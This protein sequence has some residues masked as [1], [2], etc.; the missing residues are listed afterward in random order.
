[1]TRSNRPLSNTDP[2]R[3]NDDR[4]P[5]S[6][7]LSEGTARPQAG[8]RAGLKLAAFS[9]WL[10]TYLSMF[11][12]TVVLFFSLTGITLNHP[13]FFDDGIATSREA[14]GRVAAEWVDA[15]GTDSDPGA[16]I[17]KLEV[18]EH[19]RRTHGL[20]GAL[21]SFTTDEDECVVTFKGPGYSAD[22]FIRRADGRY[23]LTEERR[24]VVAVLND[25]HKGRDAGPVWSALVDVSAALTAT[26][27][28][29]G[30]LLL[31]Y[32]KRRRATGLFLALVGA[33]VLAAAFLLG[34]P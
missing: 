16:G 26:A 27:S 5:A 9:R 6:G 29:S 22:A 15:S 21:A 12:L 11:G 1:M 19:L 30:L 24:G 32:I 18:V 20:R 8:R 33:A 31:F 10:H 3:P 17:Q 28:L 13:R 34:V 4:E 23:R 7:P 25:L 2:G 14:E